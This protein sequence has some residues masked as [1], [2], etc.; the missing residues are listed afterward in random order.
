MIPL[1]GVAIVTVHSNLKVL[2]RSSGLSLG[3]KQLE[4]YI[5]FTAYHTVEVGMKQRP[6]TND[7]LLIS[8]VCM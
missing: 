8:V 4:G 6:K 1:G 7:S 2:L 3:Q 5:N